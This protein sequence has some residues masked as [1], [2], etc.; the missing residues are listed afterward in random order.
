[1]QKKKEKIEGN[2]DLMKDE[3]F[4]WWWIMQEKIQARDYVER[5]M[6]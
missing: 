3:I 6:L 4:K 2:W 1:M 5:M